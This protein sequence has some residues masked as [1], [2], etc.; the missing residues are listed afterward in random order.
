M[1][2][3]A[4]NSKICRVGS[5]ADRCLVFG[6]SRKPRLIHGRGN[7]EYKSYPRARPGLGNSAFVAL[8]YILWDRERWVEYRVFTEFKVGARP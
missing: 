2:S 6:W 5:Q 1:E 7:G 4:Q 3:G 8:S